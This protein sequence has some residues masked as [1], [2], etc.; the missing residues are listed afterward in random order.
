[1]MTMM[2]MVRKMKS[3]LDLSVAVMR[4]RISW[5]WGHSAVMDRMFCVSW[6]QSRARRRYERP[7]TSLTPCGIMAVGK[8]KDLAR[9]PSTV[10]D[11]VLQIGSGSFLLIFLKLL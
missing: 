1:M 4:G 11:Y 8:R 5:K 7:S 3:I 6:V 10:Q 9:L 2:V